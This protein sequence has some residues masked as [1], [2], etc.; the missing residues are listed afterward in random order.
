MMDRYILI[1]KIPV[2]EPD[3]LKWAQWFETADR[4]VAETTVLEKYW[5]STVFLG[6]DHNFFA[7]PPKLFETMI[8]VLKPSGGKD[9][10]GLDYMARTSTWE[11]AL[12][13]HQDAINWL[14]DDYCEGELN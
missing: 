8:F 10:M 5:V 2:P 11:L 7:G 14:L 1:D 12:E 3:L 6:M 9:Y 13:Q 4:C